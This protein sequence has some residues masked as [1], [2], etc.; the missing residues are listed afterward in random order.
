MDAILVRP[1]PG[2]QALYE[3]MMDEW[4]AHGGRL[5]PGAL[6]RWSYRLGRAVSYAEWLG[7]MDDDRANG[8]ELFFY[9]AGG[10]LLG[11]ISLRFGNNPSIASDGH[12]GYGIRPSARRQGHAARMLSLALPLAKAKG[13]D[14]AVITCAENNIASVKV[15]ERCGGALVGYQHGNGKRERV[16]HVP[17]A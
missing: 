8:Q 11:A 3:A 5:N 17:T 4:E 15:I 16:Y 1:L 12:I 2:H 9:I 6:R 10:Q 13:I 7:W 14:P